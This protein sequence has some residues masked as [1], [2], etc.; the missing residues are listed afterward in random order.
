VPNLLTDSISILILAAGRSTRM[1]DPHL[2]KLLLPWRGGKPILWHTAN[3][4]LNLEPHEV[5]VV[6]R[7]DLPEMVEA[8]RDLPVRCVPNPRY[9]E[10]MGTSLA[11]GIQALSGNAEAALLMLGDE[12]DVPR[13]VIERLLAA[14]RGE[15]K[16]I[17]IP[18]YGEQ[19]GPPAIF[20]RCIFPELMK[21]QGDQGARSLI[22]QYPDWACILPFNEAE[23]PRDI[24][25]PD[26]YEAMKRDA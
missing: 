9:S 25:T 26:D 6:M 3:N 13:H 4:A 22:T 16:A 24:D 7:P 23:R 21:L 19:V 1:G 2:P 20:A 8:L 12:P 5:V 11:I 14:Y 15:G 10:G 17:T 18:M